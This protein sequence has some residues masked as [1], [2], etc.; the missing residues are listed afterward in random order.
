MIL[1]F[2]PLTDIVFDVYRMNPIEIESILMSDFDFHGFSRY[3]EGRF[4]LFCLTLPN[5]KFL[6]WSKLKALADDKRNVTEKLIF[7]LGR[8][9]KHYGKRRKCW[10]PAFFPF[11]TM[12]SK[13]FLPQGHKS[14][15]GLCA[16]R[17][18]KDKLPVY[19]CI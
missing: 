4:T 9:E 14:R 15:H 2:I 3:G 5:N 17:L 12:F 18:T 10:L 11:P 7:V 13:G 1:W 19:M 8:V 16:K 6:D